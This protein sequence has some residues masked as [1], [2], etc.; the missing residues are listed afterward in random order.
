MGEICGLFHPCLWT[1]WGLRL[2]CRSRMRFSITAS[3][4]MSRVMRHTHGSPSLQIFPSAI[5]L[6]AWILSTHG[7]VG[8]SHLTLPII[9][10]FIEL[11]TEVLHGSSLFLDS[12]AH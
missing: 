12:F 9:V 6:P 8:Y 7:Q 3:N 5:L 2:F 10:L 11:W 4:S 1:E